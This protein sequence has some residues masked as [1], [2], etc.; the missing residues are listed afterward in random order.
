MGGDPNALVWV[1]ITTVPM[2]WTGAVDVAQEIL[3]ILV[4]ELA[5]VPESTEFRKD[6]VHPTGS[7]SVLCLDGADVLRVFEQTVDRL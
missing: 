5:G 1:A 6:K 7:M 2:G 4:F 3:R